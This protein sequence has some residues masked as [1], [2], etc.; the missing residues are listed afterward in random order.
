MKDRGMMKWAPY[1]SLDAQADFLA[2]MAYKKGRR[3]RPHLFGAAIAEMDA[4]LASYHGETV[5]VRYYEDGYIDECI[6][7]IAT[8]D[9][10]YKRLKISGHAI[11]F[12]DLLAITPWEDE[13]FASKN[14][15]SGR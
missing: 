1:K 12:A 10:V 13:R 14:G 8:I 2:D 6:G 3:E 7:V 4:L 11:A 15:G 5:K 9:R